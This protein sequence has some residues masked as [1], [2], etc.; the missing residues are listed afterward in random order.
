MYYT[1]LLIRYNKKSQRASRLK[2]IGKNKDIVV[3]EISL[4]NKAVE[5]ISEMMIDG[6]YEE[7]MIILNVRLRDEQTI[8]QMKFEDLGEELK[9]GEL[10]IGTLTIVPNYD[11]DSSNYTS[12]EDLDG[13]HRLMGSVRA[14]R[15]YLEE[16]GKW[17]EGGLIV[18]IVVRD[19]EGAKRIVNQTFKRSDTDKSWLAS[20][21]NDDCNKFTNEVVNKTAIL[22]DTTF[23]TIEECHAYGGLTYKTIISDYIRKY[24]D[25]AV[26]SVATRK[27]MS[28]KLSKFLNILLDY[29]MYFEKKSVE[30]LKSTTLL[31]EPNIFVGYL[32]SGVTL[33]NA[34]MLS[35]DK[36]LELANKIIFLKDSQE[37]KNLKLNNKTASLKNIVSFFTKLANEVIINA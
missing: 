34:E 19:L 31:L 7:D 20:F 11:R 26:N 35:E 2:L 16:H 17:L 36:I 33:N 3:R 30:E 12:V 28:D 22:K 15:K 24:S 29:L 6:V 14:T 25:L 27:F 32:A 1:N 23:D 8:P 13:F 9:I 4:N 21:S 37:L 5:N 18:K 10:G